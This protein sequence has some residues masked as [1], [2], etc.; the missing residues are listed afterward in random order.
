MQIYSLLVNYLWYMTFFLFNKLRAI[1]KLCIPQN[2]QR[3][4]ITNE[5]YENTKHLMSLLHKK[6]QAFTH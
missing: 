3:G 6:I 4:A 5:I 2:G 1:I